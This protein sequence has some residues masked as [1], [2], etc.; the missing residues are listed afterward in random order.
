[1]P[2]LQAQ[3]K[4][5]AANSTP[6]AAHMPAYEAYPQVGVGAACAAAAGAGVAAVH[7]VAAHGAGG[8]TPTLQALSMETVVAHLQALQPQ[9]EINFLLSI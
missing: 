6:A 4:P 8:V 1:M 5:T 3:H 7:A 9:E 2:L